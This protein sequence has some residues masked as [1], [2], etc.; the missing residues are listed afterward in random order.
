MADIVRA[1]G[2]VIAATDASGN[3]YPFACAKNSS[4]AIKRDLLELTP[5]TNTAYR[6]YIK[7]RQ[8]FTVSGDGLVK[9]AESNMIPITFFD[10]FIK[11]TDQSFVAYLDMIDYQGNYKLYKFGCIFLE[12]SL[13][14]SASQFA[15]Y[16]FTLQGTGAI[17]E[18]T[19][20]D[21]YVVSGGTITGRS[22]A[23]HKLVAVG[24]EGKWYYNYVVVGT[25]ITIG[26]SFNGKTVKAAYI[27]L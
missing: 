18:L 14:S 5:K 4:I 17:T 7:S 3:V 13:S 11:N 16:N 27:A 9:M 22:T 8:T 20:V 2:L 15:Q 21:S 25:T 23:T 1:E 24:I 26:T 10:T 19:I 6:D 12:L